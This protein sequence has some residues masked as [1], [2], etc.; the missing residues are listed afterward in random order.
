MSRLDKVYGC[1]PVWAQH[2]AATLYG[3]YRYWLRFGPGFKRCVREYS[4]RER[5]TTDEWL[6][7]QQEKLKPLLALCADHV[8]YYRRTWT[9]AQKEAARVGSLADLPLLDK[10]PIRANPKAFCRDDLY[11]RFRVTFHTSGSTGTPIAT[12]WTVQEVRRVWALHETR[13][14]RWAG[15]SFHLPRATLGGRLVEPDPRSQGPFYRFNAVER[16]VYLSAFHLRPDTVRLYVQALWRHGTQWLIGYSFSSY[17]FAR[18]ILEQGLKPPPLRAL[19]T[20]AEKVTGEMRQVIKEAFSCGVYEGYGSVENVLL[21]S[22]CQEGRLHVSPDA[23]VVE[24]LRPD[25]TPCDPG[26]PGEVVATGLTRDYQPLVRYRLGDMA[27][28]DEDPCPCGRSMPVL[29]EVI[30]R[31]EDVVVGPDGREMVRFHGIFV[32]QPHVREGQIIQEELTRIRVKV[33]VTDG[34]GDS[35][36]QEIVHRIQQRL[37]AGVK[38]IVEPVDRIPRT[39]AGKFQAVVSNL[40][41]QKQETEQV[42]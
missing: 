9:Q 29:K 25:G 34:F 12:I 33:I 13:P 20:N 14:L 35:D 26:E 40:G 5:F 16:Q 24:I 2:M 7:W 31:I 36:V 23:G 32:D 15:V 11:P 30:G 8:P 41:E 10:E 18:L 28:W 19:V 38:V 21:A 4:A 6:S 42:S 27:V 22:E 3:G 39:S 17:L 1:L 37:G